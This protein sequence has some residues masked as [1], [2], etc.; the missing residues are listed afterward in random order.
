MLMGY[1][2]PPYENYKVYKIV[3]G[4]G[5]ARA[6]LYKLGEDLATSRSWAK[7]VYE[8]AYGVLI[9]DGL[10]VDHVNDDPT[11]DRL[12][13]LQ[14]LTYTEN[15]QK[16]FEHFSE[17]KEY[18]CDQCK[19]VF[20]AS[21]FGGR[22]YAGVAYCNAKCRRLAYV[23]RVREDPE[24]IPHGTHVRYAILRCRCDDCRAYKRAASKKSYKKKYT[25][26]SIMVSASGLYPD[27]S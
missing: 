21:P 10:T 14:L 16:A 11:D 15:I 19:E 9:E 3:G 17:T 4:D 12:E 13:N 18:I 25:S 6:I 20:M 23:A 24:R 26:P 1:G 5:R 27:P 22:S 8:T 2:L 7:Y